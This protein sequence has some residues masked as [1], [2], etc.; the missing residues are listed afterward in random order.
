M[1]YVS[2]YL[3]NDEVHVFMHSRSKL[4]EPN[5]SEGFAEVVKVKFIPEFQNKEMED[6]YFLHL[7]EK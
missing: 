4:V 1:I 2:Y 5:L 6:L 3:N 7:L